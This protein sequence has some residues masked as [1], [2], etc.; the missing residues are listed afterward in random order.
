MRK[1]L[2]E[3]NWCMRSKEKLGFAR[4]ISF[5]QRVQLSSTHCESE[6]SG[7]I[8]WNHSSAAIRIS[9]TQFC[10]QNFAVVE[11]GLYVPIVIS[12]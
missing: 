12:V 5:R 2:R 3:M 11:L 1:I 10:A 8:Q 7:E 9:Q 6:K 4:K